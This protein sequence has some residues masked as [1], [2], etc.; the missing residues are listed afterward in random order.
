MLAFPARAVYAPPLDSGCTELLVGVE[1][2]PVMVLL[3]NVREPDVR[4]DMVPVEALKEFM[5]RSVL[6]PIRGCLPSISCVWILRAWYTAF[7][8]IGFVLP[9]ITVASVENVLALPARP[10]KTAPLVG[11]SVEPLVIDEVTL[12]VVNTPTP[13]WNIELTSNLVATPMLFTP[14]K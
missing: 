14:I 10:V 13:F 6:P 3:P 8:W 1:S 9:E 2:T 12:L 4:N 7:P 11:T 5:V